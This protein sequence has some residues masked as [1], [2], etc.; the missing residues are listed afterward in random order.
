MNLYFIKSNLIF[1][2]KKKDTKNSKLL[3]LKRNFTTNR[4]HLFSNRMHKS[5]AFRM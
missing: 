5:N 4:E 2:L 1:F 3:Q